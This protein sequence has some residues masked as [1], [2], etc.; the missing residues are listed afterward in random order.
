MMASRLF[1]NFRRYSP[2][3]DPEGRPPGT[4]S[5]SLFR[6]QGDG[7]EGA[8][9]PLINSSHGR[10]PVVLQSRG[11]NIWKKT[12]TL[13]VPEIDREDAINDPGERLHIRRLFF[14]PIERSG[15]IGRRSSQP[16]G[17]GLISRKGH[18]ER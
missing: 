15:R 7:H 12:S 17:F 6:F 13:G 9:R 18:G 10:K 14:R 11:V 8:P 1:Q 2:P 4:I 16:A 5:V 3:A